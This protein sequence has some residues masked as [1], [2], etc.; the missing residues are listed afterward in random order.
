MSDTLPKQFLVIKKPE[1][2][3]V[4]LKWMNSAVCE[5]NLKAKTKEQGEG[6]TK[7]KAVRREPPD[8]SPCCNGRN[9]WLYISKGDG[10]ML[11]ARKQKPEG[12]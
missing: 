12:I 1:G 9:W 8:T 3:T 6:P 4:C 10:Y 5:L 2:G 11:G 7:L